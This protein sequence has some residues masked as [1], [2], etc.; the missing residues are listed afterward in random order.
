A[1]GALGLRSF[2]QRLAIQ[3]T[4]VRATTFLV[5]ETSDGG[6]CGSPVFTVADGILWLSQS[7]Q[8]NSVVRKLQVL[9][10]RGQAPMPGLHTFR[11]GQAGIQVFPRMSIPRAAAARAHPPARVATGVAGLDDLMGGGIPAGDAVLV[12]GPSGTGKSVLA[13]QFIA[14]GARRG[15]PGVIAVFEE[16]PRE[17]LA[18]AAALGFDLAAMADQGLAQILYLRLL[19]LSPDETLLEIG[20]AVRRHGARRVVIDSLAGFEL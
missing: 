18:R 13:A 8:R 4:S 1:P 2:V 11:I 16:H 7:I 14:A 12:T 10:S 17:Y 20:E 9:K 15:E 5:G 6:L 3:L 19:D